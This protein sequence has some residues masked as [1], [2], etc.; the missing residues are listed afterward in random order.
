MMFMKMRPPKGGWH[1]TCDGGPWECEA[2]DA[3]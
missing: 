2:I 1:N 3:G